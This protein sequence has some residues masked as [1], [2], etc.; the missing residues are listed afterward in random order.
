MK[1]FI[2]CAFLFLFTQAS[3]GQNNGVS[4][5]ENR[6]RGN[7]FLNVYTNKTACYVGEPIIVTYKLYSSLESV[8]DIVKN[9]S[10]YGFTYKDLI[11][12]RD[13][14]VGRETIDGVKFDVHTIRKVQLTPTETGKLQ[15]DPL[16]MSNSIKLV[17]ANGNK[18]AILDGISEDYTLRNGNYNL[19]IS[20]VPIT[21][22]VNELPDVPRPAQFQGAVG[23]FRM[24]IQMSKNNFTV[25][26]PGALI[27][28][29]SGVGDFSQVNVPLVEWPKGIHIEAAKVTGNYTKAN[30]AQGYKTFTIPFSG[31]SAGSY[32]IMPVKFSYFDVKN[33]R[34]NTITNRPVTFYITEAAPIGSPTAAVTV[35]RNENNRMALLIGAAVV[36]LLLI[37]LLAIRR[38]K[39]K[40][41]KPLI[42]GPAGGRGNNVAVIAPVSINNLLKPATDAV[43]QPGN[44]F[45][46]LLKQGIIQFFAEK[47]ALPAALFNRTALKNT[48][49]EKNISEVTQN[50][51]LN[52]LTEIEMNIYSGGGLDADKTTLL[53]KT[54]HLLNKL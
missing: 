45:Y 10:F 26:E 17:D 40:R 42:V 13:D 36:A 52:L 27:I 19:T 43:Q 49:S 21:I 25:N 29:I 11:S 1:R 12:T 30:N 31:A 4:I 14:V 20:S 22:T 37:L 35:S 24:N 7:I 28:T 51:V 44:S 23:D 50:E 6:L 3:A 18:H 39:N 48:M 2:Y 47:F 46:S 32:T 41:Y 38:T 5:L 16:V 54:Q 9:P 8:S 15:L 34:Y 33:N 53:N